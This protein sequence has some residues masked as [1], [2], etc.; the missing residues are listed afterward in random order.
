MCKFWLTPADKALVLGCI[1]LPEG[2]TQKVETCVNEQCAHAH[3]SDAS[4]A[5]RERLIQTRKR[6]VAM[7]RRLQTCLARP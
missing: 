1:N 6:K 3:T 7:A 5:N 2:V 4:A